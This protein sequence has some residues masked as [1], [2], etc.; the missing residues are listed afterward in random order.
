MVNNPGT[1]NFCCIA[2]KALITDEKGDPVLAANTM[3]DKAWNAHSLRKVRKA[4]LNGEKIQVFNYGNHRRDFTYID[5]IVEGVIR[6]LDR[7]ARSN[8]D[9]SGDDPD[10]GTSH[11]PWRIYNIGNNT[12]IDLLDY[13]TAIEDVLGIEAQKELLPLQPGDVPDTYANVDDLVSE[14]GY[15]PSMPVREGVEKF[16]NWYRNY[17]SI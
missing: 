16:V 12:P 7:P 8:A 13:I 10:T 5:D 11:A 14:I 4:M 9:W 15:K 6:V 3:P 17:N 2:W 1:Y